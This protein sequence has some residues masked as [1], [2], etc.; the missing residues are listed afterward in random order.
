MSKKNDLKSYL[1]LWKDHFSSDVEG[2]SIN[3]QHLDDEKLQQMIHLSLDMENND[4]LHLEHLSSCPACMER[5]AQL[6]KQEIT[7]KVPDTH[8]Y[9][10][11]MSYGTNEEDDVVGQSSGLNLASQCGRFTLSSTAS[12]GH[13]LTE[14]LTIKT[15]ETK[16]N[17][18]KVQVRDRSG[19]VLLDGM[20]EKGQLSAKIDIQKIDLSIWTVLV[21]D[22]TV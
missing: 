21:G 22:L 1:N 9:S 20:I 2:Q 6:C 17:G 8:T 14:N 7:E 13:L 12:A 4:N 19:S 15:S 3:G 5:W 11:S 18:K 10:P 16:L